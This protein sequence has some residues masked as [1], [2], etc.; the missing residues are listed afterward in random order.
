LL[1]E[2]IYRQQTAKICVTE[3]FCYITKLQSCNS[4]SHLPER[5]HVVLRCWR[6]KAWTSS[7]YILYGNDVIYNTSQCLLTTDKFETLPD[8]IGNIQATVDPTKLY[9]PDQVAIVTNHELQALEEAIPSE[10]P[11]LDDVRSRVAMPRRS[12]DMNPLLSTNRITTR[13]EQRSYCH[14]VTVT[15]LCV[16]TV[17][18]FIVHSLRSYTHKMIA[19][20]MIRQNTSSQNTTEPNPIHETSFTNSDENA[21]DAKSDERHCITLANAISELPE[22]G[23]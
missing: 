18:A 14:L 8:I 10:T 3:G 6:D 7:T 17:L 21:P 5:Q 4:T 12:M 19:R 15:V 2:Y 11:Q 1:I 16:I 23:A 22:V 9:V 13:R 20:C